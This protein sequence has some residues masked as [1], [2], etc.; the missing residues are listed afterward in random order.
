MYNQEGL[1][2]SAEEAKDE[3]YIELLGKAGAKTGHSIHCYRFTSLLVLYLRTL[4]QLKSKPD[5]IFSYKS[6]M[7]L[8]KK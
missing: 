3:E 5:K 2:D 8:A 6:Q 4:S 7:T 1:P